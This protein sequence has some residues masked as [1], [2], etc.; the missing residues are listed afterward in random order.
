VVGGLRDVLSR[1]QGTLLLTGPSSSGKTTTIYALLREVAESRKPPPHIV[2]V[3]DPVEYRLGHISQTE[4]RPHAG[5][6]FE[7]ALRALLRQDPE[8]IMLG[9]I[10]DAETART[11]IQAGLTG[12]LVISTIHS[13]TAAGVFTRL[14][15]M[16][17]EPFLV[18]S[19]LTGV[20]AQRLLRVTCPHCRTEYA[21]DGVVLERFGLNEN[22]GPFV[23]GAGCEQCEG[24]GYR[25][26]TAIGEMLAMTQPLSDLI[27]ERSRTSVLE[28]A[29]RHP[30]EG[31]TPMRTLVEK[32]VARVRQGT[33]TIEEV[34]RVLAPP[35][36]LG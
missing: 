14:L 18:A 6:T 9:E 15:D 30:G 17:V 1:P 22:D 7:A 8:V 21:P 31:R 13:G 11:A 2:T 32:A 29:A 4:V 36:R 3:E 26:R 27:L 20:L 34:A 25:G 28:E 19:S 16:G 10:R 33:T 12:H 35:E 24:L 23:R 5:F